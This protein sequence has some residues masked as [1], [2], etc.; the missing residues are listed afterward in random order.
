MPGGKGSLTE[1][2]LIA[3]L[4]VMWSFRVDVG[5][6]P[7]YVYTFCAVYWGYLA[8]RRS[9]IVEGFLKGLLGK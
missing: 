6:L 1:A 8:T 5:S 9:Y 4:F 3:Y 7:W 2:I